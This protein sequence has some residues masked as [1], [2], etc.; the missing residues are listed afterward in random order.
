M[1]KSSE[2]PSKTIDK[3]PGNGG[4]FPPLRRNRPTEVLLYIS[5]DDTSDDSRQRELFPK[6][7]RIRPRTSRDF[8][9]QVRAVL[10]AFMPT[11]RG[12]EQDTMESRVRGGR[13]K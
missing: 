4:R 13:E 8:R 7:S 5:S 1:I 3:S 11:P 2:V 10:E 9:R 12:E 6:M